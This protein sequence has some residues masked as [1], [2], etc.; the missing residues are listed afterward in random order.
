MDTTECE[1]ASATSAGESE[2]EIE[3]SSCPHVLWGMQGTPYVYCR[4]SNSSGLQY[5]TQAVAQRQQ[6]QQSRQA[7]S[8]INGYNQQQ[9]QHHSQYM[10]VEGGV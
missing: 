9:E 6:Q 1:D 3:E 2:H 4:E 7:N 5:L 8:I 10:D